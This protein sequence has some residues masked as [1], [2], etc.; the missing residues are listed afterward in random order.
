MHIKPQVAQTLRA[1][2][3]PVPRLQTGFGRAGPHTLSAC[4]HARYFDTIGR[5]CGTYIE[6]NN[7]LLKLAQQILHAFPQWR[8]AEVVQQAGF[9]LVCPILQGKNPRQVHVHPFRLG[10]I[11]VLLAALF[12]GPYLPR[13]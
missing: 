1:G 12:V 6:K 7:A 8:N 4:R 3:R 9:N 13:P 11:I 2:K 5:G 10:E